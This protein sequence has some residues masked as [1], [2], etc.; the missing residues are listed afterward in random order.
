MILEWH[1]CDWNDEGR[2]IQKPCA[3]QDDSISPDSSWEPRCCMEHISS[4]RRHICCNRPI[5]NEKC[6]RSRHSHWRHA[7][8]GTN[9]EPSFYNLPTDLKRHGFSTNSEHPVPCKVN[10]KEGR[11]ELMTVELSKQRTKTRHLEFS[12]DPKSE[13]G[14]NPKVELNEIVFLNPIY[15]LIIIIFNFLIQ[16]LW[17]SDQATC[18]MRISAA[19]T[20]SLWRCVGHC[21]MSQPVAASDSLQSLQAQVALERVL[22][23]QPPHMETLCSNFGTKIICEEFAMWVFLFC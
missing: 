7:G 23:T 10:G 20:T 19:R 8:E 13:I 16:K 6:C 22:V 1:P 21:H 9:L 15:F 4:T 12:T 11:L 3:Q 2:N 17:V 5:F 18:R 14:W